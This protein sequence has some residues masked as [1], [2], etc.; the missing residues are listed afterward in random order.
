MTERL[1]ASTKRANDALATLQAFEALSEEQALLI[2]KAKAILT[3][4]V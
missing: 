4:K 3:Y 2:S 1:S